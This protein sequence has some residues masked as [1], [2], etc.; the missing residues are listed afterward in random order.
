M[1][2]TK[3]WHIVLHERAKE[4]SIWE[5]MN[6]VQKQKPNSSVTSNNFK[7]KTIKNMTRKLQHYIKIVV[8]IIKATGVIT[9]NFSFLKAP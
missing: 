9:I 2:I 4:I 3:K 8:K 6:G 1:S 5:G 7:H